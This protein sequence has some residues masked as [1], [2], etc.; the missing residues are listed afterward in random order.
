MSSLYLSEPQDIIAGPTYHVQSLSVRATRHHSRAH[1][2]CPVSICQSHKTSQQGP[3]IMSSLYLSEPQDTIAGPTYHV[4]SLSVRATRHHSRAH[5]SCPVS[6]CQSH[7]TSQQG[8]LAMPSLHLSEPQDT[9]AGPTCHVQSLSVR[10][11]RHHSR[12]H[13]S[14][15]VS[16][17]QSHKTSHQG[18]L[19][20]S[21]HYLS[22]P[23]D[24]TA[25]PTC[26]VQSLSVRATRH[27]SRAHL[28]C[29]VSICQSH[30]TS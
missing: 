23:Q 29:P 16:I 4:Q 5:L 30:K 13:L 8:P 14:C 10:A 24:I 3:L 6:I 2:S 20:M 18:P 28:P 15:P 9:I 21:S 26:H 11:T 19:V 7:K 17:C 1:L 25:G 12:A 22:E 27:H